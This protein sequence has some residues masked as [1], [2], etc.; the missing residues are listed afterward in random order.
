MKTAKKISV[1]C[2]I[3]GRTVD[4][5]NSPDRPFC[6]PRCRL[7]DLGKWSTGEYRIPG[8]KPADKENDETTTS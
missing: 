7:L 1:N 2:P 4:W 5:C 6:S 3:C 8:E